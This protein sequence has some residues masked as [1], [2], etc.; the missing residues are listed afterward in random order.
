MIAG[1]KESWNEL[2]EAAKVHFDDSDEGQKEEV[3]EKGVYV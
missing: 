3:K 1:I 2:Y